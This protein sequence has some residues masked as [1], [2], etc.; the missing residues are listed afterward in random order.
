MAL[1][2]SGA[3]SLNDIHQEAGGTSGTQASIND[4]D[5]RD[6]ISKSSGATMSFNEW[7]GASAGA[8][9]G[10]RWV[11]GGGDR[12][13]QSGSGV[14]YDS[15]GYGNME[16]MQY[17]DFNTGGTSSLFG[18]LTDSIYGA[19][20]SSNGSRIVYS[21]QQ[22]Y[23]SW[24]KYGHDRM[25]YITVGTTGNA[26]T[27][28]TLATPGRSGAAAMNTNGRG[29]D[30]PG[31]VG[32]TNSFSSNINYFQIDTTGNASTFGTI[33]WGTMDCAGTEALSG[34]CMFIGG[35][36]YSSTNFNSMLY[37]S[38][39][40]SVGGTGGDFGDMATR[41]RYVSAC[42]NGTR[43]LIWGG[44]G[45]AVYSNTLEDRYNTEYVTIGTTG[46]ASNFGNIT[47]ARWMAASTSNGTRGILISGYNVSGT[48]NYTFQ[49]I[50]YV[51]I[52]TT[53][54]ASNFGNLQ[55]YARSFD[56]ASGN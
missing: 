10:D 13:H 1:Q 9:W 21:G 18:S 28:G 27:F 46:N 6:M 49:S 51:A 2:T 44:A 17:D 29:L 8:I 5:I 25:K 54:N 20:A 40:Q 11:T 42:T 30:S 15:L 41:R 24:T 43:A 16:E 38:S 34:R 37:I 14:S 48:Y 22:W 47:Y 3:I 35:G 36:R 56:A 32:S 23:G 7:Y 53:G 33:P 26:S 50:E 19:R 45:H 52:G 39:T 31:A 12:F 4:S 55:Y